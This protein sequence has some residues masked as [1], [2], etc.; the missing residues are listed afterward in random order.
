MTVGIT[1]EYL[2]GLDHPGL[3]NV[4]SDSNRWVNGQFD[5]LGQTNAAARAA[6]LASAPT[7]A[8]RD[9]IAPR[10]VTRSRFG[11][12]KADQTAANTPAAQEPASTV[13][14]PVRVA[15]RPTED[16]NDYVRIHGDAQLVN[17]QGQQVSFAQLRQDLERE[18][19]AAP[20]SVER[21]LMSDFGVQATVDS[22]GQ[23]NGWAIHRSRLT[24]ES[25]EAV[26]AVGPANTNFP[27]G[28]MAMRNAAMAGGAPGRWSGASREQEHPINRIAVRLH[29]LREPVLRPLRPSA[30]SCAHGHSS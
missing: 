21:K 3:R 28:D 11:T 24:P 18:P 2:N 5:F 13:T 27:G 14:G 29:V 4:V 12:A 17:A 23:R 9:A 25:R 7:A 19:G 8:A 10:L 20:A 16:T 22:S 15:R 30:V 6:G 1:N 26:G